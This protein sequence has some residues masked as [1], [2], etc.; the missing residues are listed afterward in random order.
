MKV[1]LI[2]AS[3]AVLISGVVWLLLWVT[4]FQMFMDDIENIWED[5]DL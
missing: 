3:A 1:I 2:A 5:D 4:S